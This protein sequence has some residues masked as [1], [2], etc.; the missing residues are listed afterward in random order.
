MSRL[1]W[2]LVLVIIC[3]GS[4][5]AVRPWARILYK[6]QCP[7]D[8]IRDSLRKSEMRRIIKYI[9]RPS[10]GSCTRDELILELTRPNV[11][12]CLSPVSTMRKWVVDWLADKG[13]RAG[14]PV[15]NKKKLSLEWKLVVHSPTVLPTS[16]PPGTEGAQLEEFQYSLKHHFFL[17]IAATALNTSDFCVAHTLSVGETYATC[18]YGLPGSPEDLL[19]EGGF[20]QGGVENISASALGP[21]RPNPHTNQRKAQVGTLGNAQ[22]PTKCL[23]LSNHTLPEDPRRGGPDLNNPEVPFSLNC[24]RIQNLHSSLFDVY[25]PLGFFLLCGHQ[26]YTYI[27]AYS[28]GGPCALGRLTSLAAL[29]SRESIQRILAQP[30]RTRGDLGKE[31]CEGVVAYMPR[32]LTPAEYI[33]LAS[34][35]VGLPGSNI[36]LHQL[37]N[38]LACLLQQ[39]VN[40][41]SEAI[42]LLMELLDQVR[43]GVLQNRVAID[44]LLLKNNYGCEHFE[45][46]CCFNITDNKAPLEKKLKELREVTKTLV[47]EKEGWW[48]KSFFSWL[49]NLSWLRNLVIS[50]IIIVSQALMGCCCFQCCCNLLSMIPKARFGDHVSPGLVML[51]REEIAEM[52]EQNSMLYK[53]VAPQNRGGR[54]PFELCV[55]AIKFDLKF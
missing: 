45:G 43:T 33:A 19:R 22:N 34:S 21:S 31:E 7:K 39:T 2:G 29:P 27:P 13:G 10:Q 25:L 28:Q 47:I 40:K 51:T 36:Q 55:I 53:E 41:T 20:I 48:W 6:C 32:L 35:I 12:V 15:P 38:G 30:H 8:K 42:A 9:H 52:K 1:Y 49:P 37:I 11:F 50:I 5:G 3:M 23:L 17:E 16:T 46:L 26:A 54:L 14:D 4:A 24:S 44:Y 18:M